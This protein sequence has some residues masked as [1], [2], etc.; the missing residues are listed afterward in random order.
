[1]A[2]DEWRIRQN[3]KEIGP[4][5][6]AN[7]V[8][9]VASGQITSNTL[10]RQGREQWVAAN[11]IKGL[12]EKAAQLKQAKSSS[13]LTELQRKQQKL[14]QVVNSLVVLK[15]REQELRRRSQNR[16][17]LVTAIRGT[18]LAI[19]LFSRYEDVLFGNEDEF[20]TFGQSDSSMDDVLIDELFNDFFETISFI[21]VSNV[22]V[23]V[24]SIDVT[25]LSL[26]DLEATQVELESLLA[27]VH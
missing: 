8:Q 3:G 13:A 11:Q 1:M 16:R 17:L 19:S 4:I 10:V 5:T 25:G 7:L 6:A 18:F 21:D 14:E 22:N 20:D 12:F 15:K 2:A 27:V 9:A 26:F 23:L 24:E